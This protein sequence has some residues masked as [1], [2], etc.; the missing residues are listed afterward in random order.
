[1]KEK[2]L[3]NVVIPL[4]LNQ[5][6][7]YSCKSKIDIGTHLKVPFGNNNETAEA[8]TI[9]YSYSKETSFP[10]KSI[11]SIQKKVLSKKQIKFFMWASKY[12]LVE[13]PKV[14]NSLFPKHI[15]NIKKIN[16]NENKYRVDNLFKC[17]VV[18]ENSINYISYVE[19]KLEKLNKNKSQILILCPNILKSYELEKK[20]K[21]K[22]YL[23]NSSISNKDSKGIW[24]KVL[25]NEDLIVIGVKSALFLPFTNLSQIFVVDENDL[26][27][28][29]NDKVLR[30]NARDSA[31]MLSKIHNCE[32]N[33][34]CNYPSIESTKNIKEKKYNIINKKDP[35]EL[36]VGDRVNINNILEKKVKEQYSDF[37]SDNIRNKI[38]DR[39]K[40]N[41]KTLIFTPLLSNIKTI[42]KSLSFLSGKNHKVYELITKKLTTKTKINNLIKTIEKF[43]I[44]IGNQSILFNSLF[45]NFDLIVLIEPEKIGKRSN[46]R[47]NEI[48]FN[49]LYKSVNY[50]KY[51]QSSSL[52]ILTNESQNKI[53]KSAIKLDY[54]G[55]IKGELIERKLFKYP[56]YSK[57]IK[58]ELISSNYIKK[59]KM[60]KF[61]FENIKKDFKNLNVK[62]I[63]FDS[64]DDKYEIIIKIT[65]TKPLS[66]IKEKI[67]KF[68]NK[69]IKNNG[70]SEI[71]INIDIDP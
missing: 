27:Y 38:I 7:T 58:I 68:L 48:F 20:L 54:K 1:M 33:L 34:L 51:N 28:K 2:Y 3:V 47:S 53:F 6:Y 32:I 19:N 42:R 12:Y 71:L 35:Y 43:D 56:P 57:I 30:F 70:F 44:I 64:N 40:K 13:L 46:Y 55:F 24:E 17:T 23:Y 29:E 14:I 31:V 65:D 49:L 25:N 16:K 21:S 15:F 69:K 10:I 50:L 22:A 36:K 26:A 45:E 5:H 67:K 66:S 60:G 9:S 37:L 59:S 4:P 39:F 8:I 62:D 61:L 11:L 52:I 41:K 63:G 18:V